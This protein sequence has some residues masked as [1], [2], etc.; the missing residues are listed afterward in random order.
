MAYEGTSIAAL[1][2]IDNRQLTKAI[3]TLMGICTGITADNQLNDQEILFLSTWL[4]EY[5]ETVTKWPGSIIAER[6]SH[7]L[8]DGI[9]T[10]DEREDLFETL[11]RLQGNYFSDT[12]SAKNEIAF[13]DYCIDKQ[14]FFTEKQFCFTGEFLLGTRAVCKRI[15]E[16]VGGL[17]VENVSM[18]LDYLV[19][20]TILSEEWAFTSYGRKIEKAMGLRNSLSRPNI[21]S[22]KQWTEAIKDYIV[23]ECK[24]IDTSFP[25]LQEGNIYSYLK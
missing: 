18:K 17:T 11:S 4:K 22:E 20:G 7:I 12:G 24:T 6:I 3:Q 16:K 15:T 5:P 9:I 8:S 1:K 2:S 10:Q 25:L 14:I 13:I 21:I 23:T 19:I